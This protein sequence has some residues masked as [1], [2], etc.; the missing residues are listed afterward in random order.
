[1]DQGKIQ[2]LTA[3]FTN[4]FLLNIWPCI[5]FNSQYD[6]QGKEDLNFR[7]LHV[8]FS[9][10]R[11]MNKGLG[12]P[13]EGVTCI[14]NNDLHVDTKI[15]NE[16][17]GEHRNV[18]S[19]LESPEPR[20]LA[21]SC[22]SPSSFSSEAMVDGF[23]LF[24]ASEVGRQS[25]P[26][27]LQSSSPKHKLRCLGDRNEKVSTRQVTP[28]QHIQMDQ[29]EGHKASGRN[30]NTD[31]DWGI[32]HSDS[33]R[34]RIS[35]NQPDRNHRRFIDDSQY[36]EYTNRSI[37]VGSRSTYSHYKYDFTAHQSR[38]GIPSE[39]YRNAYFRCAAR[40]T[41]RPP[42]LLSSN[43][44]NENNFRRSRELDDA[45][46]ALLEFEAL[47]TDPLPLESIH[48]TAHTNQTGT[49]AT[50]TNGCDVSVTAE[51]FLF[52]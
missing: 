17:L 49:G 36:T 12:T 2:W 44:V 10:K 31:S 21:S 4:W 43:S 24:D 13:I 9:A 7:L 38:A 3:G 25:T 11:V 8:Y 34:E 48:A 27:V 20:S 52:E 40:T 30:T 23:N 33:T 22:L 47:W 41:S 1:M 39:R 50:A 15:T 28:S 37:D 45:E 6:S 16:T 42:A 18:D 19:L 26:P 32:E 46:V 29:C 5:F 14:V 51:V 35:F